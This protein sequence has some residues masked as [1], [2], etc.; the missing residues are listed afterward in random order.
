MFLDIVQIGDFDSARPT[1]F[2]DWSISRTDNRTLQVVIRDDYRDAGI[3]TSLFQ[4]K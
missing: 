3:G 2:F 1:P 4:V